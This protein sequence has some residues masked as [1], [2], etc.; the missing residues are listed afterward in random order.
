MR[1]RLDHLA[2]EFRNC[3]TQLSDPALVADRERYVAVSRRYKELQPIH[4]QFRGW[5]PE[6]YVNKLATVPYHPGAIKFYKE[7]GAWTAEH[8]KLQER[9][10]KGELPSLD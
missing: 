4:P 9:L 2:Q 10:L 5:K 7:K 6:I 8:D 1:D 3:E